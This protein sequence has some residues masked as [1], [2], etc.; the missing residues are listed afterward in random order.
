MKKLF[1]VGAGL[2][3]L[4]EMANVYF[5]MPMPYSQ[6]WHSIDLAY[7]LHSWRWLFRVAAGVFI[8]LGISAAWRSGNWQKVAVVASLLAAAGVAYSA[9]FSARMEADFLQLPQ[10]P[11]PGA[12]HSG[13]PLP[14]QEMNRTSLPRRSHRLVWQIAAASGG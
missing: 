9:N 8:A 5:I 12:N 11:C 1:Y 6:R 10:L 2:L 14:L 4:F 7:A 13:I 3:A